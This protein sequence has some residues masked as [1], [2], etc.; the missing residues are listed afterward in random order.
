MRPCGP[1]SRWAFGWLYL[2]A[3]LGLGACLADDMGLGKTI[4]VLSLL[5]VLKTPGGR[6]TPAEPAGGPG[7]PAGELGLGDRALCA[8]LE[9]DHRPSIGPPR[10]RPQDGTAEGTRGSGSG[11]H[12]LRLA[13]ACAVACRKRL[14]TG[15]PGRGPGHQEP[16]RQTDPDGQSLEVAG[17]LRAHRHTHRKPSR[18][19]VVALRFRE[20]RAAGI[21]QRVHQLHQRTGQPART[22]PSDRCENW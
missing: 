18:G 8:R 17:A 19:P 15:G 16:Q 21:V 1:T 6:P 9:V 12:Q 10:Q 22:I 2:I 11:H 20:P 13:A 7:F 3:K 4:Q 14:A 5:L